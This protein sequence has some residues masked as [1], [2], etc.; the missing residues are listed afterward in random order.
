MVPKYVVTKSETKQES[1]QEMHL[2]EGDDITVK[3]GEGK[4]LS[5]TSTGQELRLDRTSS[6]GNS[7]DCE[8][9]TSRTPTPSFPPVVS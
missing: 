9:H 8:S 7:L 1:V 6:T 4:D 5:G 2:K 3:T